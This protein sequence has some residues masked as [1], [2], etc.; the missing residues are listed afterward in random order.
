[1]SRGGRFVGQVERLRII[2]ARKLDHFLARDVALPKS[3]N[4]THF[5]IF[6]VSHEGRVDLLYAY[7]NW[8]VEM[9]RNR[10]DGRVPGYPLIR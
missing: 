2:L 7:V 1:M 10:S 9:A 5:Q 3:G 8:A 6:I 4:G